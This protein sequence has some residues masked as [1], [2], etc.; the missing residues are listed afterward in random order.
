MGS[1]FRTALEIT[2]ETYKLLLLE[3]V[4]NSV[5]FHIIPHV[6][7]ENTRRT[8]CKF[9][10]HVQSVF[11]VKKCRQ[12]EKITNSHTIYISIIDYR[13]LANNKSYDKVVFF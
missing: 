3:S 6:R 9:V 7:F 2:A 13:L 11:N 5:V 12:V 1:V 4:Y 8:I 10:C